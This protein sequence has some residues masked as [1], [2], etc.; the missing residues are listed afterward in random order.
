MLSTIVG[1]FKINGKWVSSFR[2]DG[3]QYLTKSCKVWS[4]IKNRCNPNNRYQKKQ[5]TYVGCC[6][7]AT[8]A[9]FQKFTDWHV[10]QIGF[11]LPDYEIDKDILVKSNREYSED[12]CVLVPNKLNLFLCDRSRFRGEYPVGVSWCKNSKKFRAQIRIDSCKK[13]IGYYTTIDGA[14]T[15]YKAA[16]EAEAFRWYERLSS[17]EFIVDPRVTERMRVWRLD[18]ELTNV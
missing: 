13:S 7:S 10:S 1:N 16:K 9:D 18:E 11:G 3:I 14:Y 8:F 6:M 17:G 2:R 12:L 5:P 15:A 4:D